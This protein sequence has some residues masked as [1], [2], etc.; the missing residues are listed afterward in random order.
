MSN[1]CGNK[2]E[3]L[4]DNFE[5]CTCDNELNSYDSKHGADEDCEWLHTVNIRTNA[6]H[7]YL[8]KK[9]YYETWMRE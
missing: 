7:Y 8:R 9:W 5:E 2:I 4:S 3:I 6:M 1:L